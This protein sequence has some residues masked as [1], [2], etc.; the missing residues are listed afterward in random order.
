MTGPRQSSPGEATAWRWSRF[1][2]AAVAGV[3]GWA[4]L[5]RAGSFW[6][7][8][9]LA[10]DWG[11]W[12]DQA[13]R[14]R[15]LARW[16]LV[17]W[18]PDWD[19]GIP[20]F[21]GYQTLPHAAA[22]AMVHFGGASIPRAMMMSVALLLLAY[23]LGG[24]L[25]L[26]WLGCGVP[27]AILG[28]ALLL[29]LPAVAGP[30]RDY[31]SLFGLALVPILFWVVIGLLGTRRGY[32]GA[33]VVGLSPYLHPFSS[34]AAG[35]LLAV[36][37]AYERR[38]SRR[39]VGQLLLA[40]LVAS[41]YW[42]P[43]ALA[44]RPRFEDPWN[45]SRGFEQSMRPAEGLLGMS[46]VLLGVAAAAWSFVRPGNTRSA[47]VSRYGLESA[48]VLGIGAIL[49][50]QGWLPRQLM[51]TDPMRWLPEVGTLLALGAAPLGDAAWAWVSAGRRSS[52]PSA[53]LLAAGLVGAMVVAAL[54]EGAIWYR[55]SNVPLAQVVNYDPGLGTWAESQ[56]LP[57]PTSIWAS[58]DDIATSSFVNFGR[59]DYTADYVSQRQWT[60]TA[61][62]LQELM[63]DDVPGMPART[64]RF[65]VIE[66]YL[67]MY[68]VRF[69]YLARFAPSTAAFLR[70]PLAGKLNRVADVPG[71]FIMEVPWTPVEAFSAPMGEVRATTLPDSSF[72]DY[73]DQVE[74]DRLV[75]AYATVAYSER[76]RPAAMSW[77][78]PTHV[79]IR[80]QAGT[81][82]VLVV[83]QNWD[84][85]W[86][87]RSG[88]RLLPV[89]RVGPNFLAIDT[90]SLS[91]AVTVELSHERYLS[92]TVSV[93]L[94][95]LALAVSLVATFVD[96]RPS[97]LVAPARGDLQA[98]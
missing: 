29:D 62:V 60:Q 38:V 21:Q 88:S 42:L 28:A 97:P 72:L 1:D 33:V 84:T 54:L 61:P 69:V 8:G 77:R 43:L 85:V 53:A 92:W 79:A 83:P 26:R 2:L 11:D 16:G 87:A 94:A 73:R 64:G 52:R 55:R 44:A 12:G 22:L 91:G 19:R 75:R 20:L 50:Y 49:A 90:S 41:F 63:Q 37:L 46:L 74:R 51:E 24:Y 18:D 4:W 89:S 17:N 96:R 98:P 5:S 14:V 65:E 15:Y 56:R 3:L 6:S 58:N 70:G 78:D 9:W 36:R 67:R 95:C 31:T 30:V 23:P 66:P 13:Y 40:L 35:A 27:G 10:I 80:A 71:G 57:T 34:V 7:H 39:L 45:W 32:L 68:G 82:D 59:F 86:V 48:L 76:S 25:A 81:G 47:R 93:V